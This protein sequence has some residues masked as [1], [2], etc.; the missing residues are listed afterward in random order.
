[1]SLINYRGLQIA[2]TTSGDG[3]TALNGNFTEI[4]NR[5]GPINYTAIVPP[6]ATDDINGGYYQGSRWQNTATDQEYVCFDNTATAAVWKQTT[7]ALLIA[8]DL[9][10]LSA[11]SVAR[12][13]LG[14]AIGSN[15]QAWS[16]SLDGVAAGTYAGSSAI[17]TL[18]TV[19]T[20]TWNGTAVSGQYG[21]TGVNNSGKT[22]TLGGNL[23]TSGAN[24]LTLTTTGATNVTLPTFGTLLSTAVAVSIAQGGT[25]QTTA[26]AGFNALSPLTTAGDMLYGGTSGTGTRLAAGSSGQVL[27]GGAT[28]VWSAVSLTADVSGSLPVANGGTGSTTASGTRTALGLEI[29]TNVE[30]WSATLDAVAGGTYAGATS[31]TTLGT[32]ATGAW[33]GTTIAVASG[34]TGQTSASAAI[35]A[36]LPSQN[37]QSG[38]FLTTDGSSAAW[39]AA[40]NPFNQTLNTTSSPTFVTVTLGTGSGPSTSSLLAL[41]AL[42]YG[43]SGGVLGQPTAW[44]NINGKQVPAY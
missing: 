2:S 44:V 8:N 36:L 25:G 43:G 33:S 30:A 16:A 15:V 4:A 23:V 42:I 24:S 20:G 26:S 14:V 10:D 1:M 31:I 34:G 35:N 7:G 32:I 29:G 17:T 11:P 9:S 6:A 5:V 27:H 22:I 38:K 19:A 28:P 13:N 39:G 3:G 18:G 40:G 21:G 12:T 37:S 41:P